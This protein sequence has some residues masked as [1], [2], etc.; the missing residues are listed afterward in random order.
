MSDYF[1][2]DEL[3]ESV[4]HDNFVDP[5]LITGLKDFYN[6]ITPKFAEE[7][8]HMDPSHLKINDI[9]ASFDVAGEETAS[10]ICFDYLNA[11]NRAKSG[12]FR[13][14]D[15]EVYRQFKKKYQNDF[16]IIKEMRDAV[17]TNL[18]KLGRDPGWIWTTSIF[19]FNKPFEIHTDGVDTPLKSQNRPEK[20]ED[21]NPKQY[22]PNKAT[23]CAGHQGLINI[24]AGPTAGTVTFNQWYPYSVYLNYGAEI[25]GTWSVGPAPKKRIICFGKGDEPTRF[26][27]HIRNFTDAP[28]SDE[29]YA[30]IMEH[31]EDH[32][33]VF[34]QEEGYGTS[35]EKILYFGEPGKL[36]SWDS[37]RFHKTKPFNHFYQHKLHNES[38]MCYAYM[39]TML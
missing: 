27:E 4:E 21:L 23:P 35:L 8:A 12:L 9:W 25:E 22:K 30:R 3:H 13:S 29:D 32:T 18:T 28:M 33:R 7:I 20:W 37:K 5:A 6:Y 36:I 19:N 1:Y 34:N 17:H 16:N 10:F 11:V 2:K 14:A 15:N 24:D 31:V 39:S 26:G 38:R